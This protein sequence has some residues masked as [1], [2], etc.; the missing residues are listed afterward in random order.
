[1]SGS[2]GVQLGRVCPQCGREDSVPLLWGLPDAEAMRLA[3]RGL[4]AL[5]GCLVP[6]ESPALHCRACG[7]DWGY[8]GDPTADEQA[9][10]EALG[11]RY[12]DVLRALGTGWRRASIATDGAEWFVSG[13]PAQV[14]VGVTGP[15]FVLARP[16][17]RWGSGVD[18]QPAD[19]RQFGRDDLL[20]DSEIVAAGAD[21]IA[22]RRRRSFRWCRSCRRVHPPEWF[23]GT[24]R[25]CQDCEAAY[26]H[27]DA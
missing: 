2:V 26:E 6:G 9:L 21:E 16:L 4:V 13:E 23:V 12:P 1:M 5:R 17:T 22:S 20:Y 27:V 25:V 18:L 3:G 24:E 8:P 19:Q 15:W 7:L 11:V 14:A 10:A